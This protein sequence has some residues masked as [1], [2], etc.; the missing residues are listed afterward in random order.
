MEVLELGR[1]HMES[2]FEAVRNNEPNIVKY[3]IG[4]G[5]DINAKNWAGDNALLKACYW[6]NTEI[7][8]LLLSIEC[9]DVDAQ[10]W[11]GITPLQMAVNRNYTEIVD[12]LKAR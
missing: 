1:V 9:I 12:L 5:I 10:D 7:V 6:G 4:Q 8:K 3:Y 2:W 11:W